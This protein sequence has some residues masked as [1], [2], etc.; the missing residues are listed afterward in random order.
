MSAPNTNDRMDVDREGGGGDGGTATERARQRMRHMGREERERG[1]AA[2]WEEAVR[3]GLGAREDVGG[4]RDA[5]WA[6]RMRRKKEEFLGLCAR[7][8]DLLHE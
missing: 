6:E 5:E 4:P 1:A 7:A 3:G 8:W 2:Y